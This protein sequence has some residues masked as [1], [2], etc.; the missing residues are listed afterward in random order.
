M[1]AAMMISVCCAAL[2][3]CS[4]A[5]KTDLK[6]PIEISYY[7]CEGKRTYLSE[8]LR[9][10]AGRQKVEQV[11][12]ILGFRREMVNLP[13]K[14]FITN[15]IYLDGMSFDTSDLPEGI[16]VFSESFGDISFY[17]RFGPRIEPTLQTDIDFNFFNRRGSVGQL[18][19]S[20]KYLNYRDLFSCREITDP[21][22]L[23]EVPNKMDGGTLGGEN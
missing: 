15:E 12:R 22:E 6:N 9:D 7:F 11:K 13:D 14:S 2:L 3:G 5:G 16:T 20:S 17:R 10:E 23:R 18:N 4:D 8:E 1:K 21:K 19:A